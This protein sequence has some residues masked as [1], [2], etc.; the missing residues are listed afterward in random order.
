MLYSGEGV[1]KDSEQAYKLF[2]EM[3]AAGWTH[4][5]KLQTL[6]PV[7]LAL[8]AFTLKDYYEYFTNLF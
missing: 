7:Y 5:G 1:T 2:D 3:I 4:K 6:L 8:Y